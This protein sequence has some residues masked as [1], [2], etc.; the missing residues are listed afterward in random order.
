M[1][2]EKEIDEMIQSH[3]EDNE[4]MTKEEIQHEKNI[5]YAQDYD[6]EQRSQY[7]DDTLN[8]MSKED[9]IKFIKEN[10]DEGNLLDYFGYEKGE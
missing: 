8:C 2:E 9:L 6:S 7:L 5:E 10:N 4:I 1:N 3:I